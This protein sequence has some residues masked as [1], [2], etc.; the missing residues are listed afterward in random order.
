MSYISIGKE[1][2][3]TLHLGGDRL[4]KEGYFIQPTIFTDC[5]PEM[6]ISREEIFGPVAA[7]VKFKT[8]EEAIELANDTVYGLACHVFSQNVSRAIRVAH[9]LEAGS[10][11]VCLYVLL[12]HFHFV[13]VELRNLIALQVNC[14]Q[15]V[16]ISVP[17]GGYKQS[18]NGREL[19]E[20]ALDT[21]VFQGYSVL[22]RPGTDPFH[23]YTQ[24]KAVHINLGTNL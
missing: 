17:F 16:D 5:R 22:Q 8:E 18:G 7:V 12:S 13:R 4:G 11:W 19:G 21:Y 24:V 10:A 23:R 15:H 14:A 6:R 9:A 3:A 20:Y 1:E 2:G